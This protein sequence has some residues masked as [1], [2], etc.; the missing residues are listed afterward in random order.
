MDVARS[1][2]PESDDLTIQR[3]AYVEHARLVQGRC[4]GL[5]F[6]NNHAEWEFLSA[7]FGPLLLEHEKRRTVQSDALPEIVRK[8]PA[9]VQIEQPSAR[10]PQP[11]IRRVAVHAVLRE[12]LDGVVLVPVGLVLHAE[13]LLAAVRYRKR[14]GAYDD[15]RRPGGDSQPDP[16]L[17]DKRESY[18]YQEGERG[19]D[20]VERAV[21]D[22]LRRGVVRAQEGE[23][24]EREGSQE[25]GKEE[26]LGLSALVENTLNTGPRGGDEYQIRQERDCYEPRGSGHARE[27]RMHIVVRHQECARSRHDEFYWRPG[28]GAVP[29]GQPDAHEDEEE[30]DCEVQVEVRGRGEEVQV[31]EGYV[32]VVED[33]EAPGGYD[34][35]QV[36]VVVSGHG[37]DRLIIDGPLVREVEY[38]GEGHDHITRYCDEMMSEHEEKEGGGHQDAV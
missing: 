35:D 3:S 36:E 14:G 18:A 20:E 9:P 25:H 27:D 38:D 4:Y 6:D 11:L 10:L 26:V 37:Q 29:A 7:F 13:Q 32:A 2:R 8:P 28:H 30:R 5:I 34:G 1:S 24:D 19:H 31:R 15:E 23:Q 16:P 22:Q 12:P 33:R 17:D 21:D